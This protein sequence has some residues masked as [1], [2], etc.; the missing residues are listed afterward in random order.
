MTDYERFVAKEAVEQEVRNAQWEEITWMR[1]TFE[2]VFDGAEEWSSPLRMRK[3]LHS[4][5]ESGPGGDIITH[6]WKK[7]KKSDAK[8]QLLAIR[9][10]LAEAVRKR[11]MY[12]YKEEEPVV[13]DSVGGVMD[14]LARMTCGRDEEEEE[15][16][17]EEFWAE[18]EIENKSRR[19]EG[20][21]VPESVS[22]MRLS[23]AELKK[24]AVHHKIKGRSVM[25]KVKLVE[26][27]VTK[28]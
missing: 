24:V 6:V 23:Q 16:E 17:E 5:R 20:W 27:I 13:E 18:W 12:E 15:T 25:T 28:P 7:I 22:L 19:P 14:M 9:A 2:N 8:K 1:E 11:D 4:T 3:V 10:R 26:A 21:D